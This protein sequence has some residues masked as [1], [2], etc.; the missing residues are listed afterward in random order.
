MSGAAWSGFLCS[1]FV[2]NIVT[3]ELPLLL[4]STAKLGASMPAPK[5]AH[6]GPAMPSRSFAHLDAAVSTFGLSRPGPAM[7][8]PAG[9]TLES[10]TFLRSHSRMDAALPALGLSKPDSSISPRSLA[11]PGLPALALRPADLGLL[12]SLQ[13]SSRAEF[14]VLLVGLARLGPCLS[15]LDRVTVESLPFTRSF[16]RVELALLTL[17]ASQP[18]SS[19]SL[20]SSS[21]SGA[22]A[23]PWGTARTGSCLLA[24]D[25]GSTASIPSTRSLA[26]VDLAVF[27]LNRAHYEPLLPSQR[28][29][30]PRLT[31]LQQQGQSTKKC[32]SPSQS[33]QTEG[34]LVVRNLN[35]WR[36][37]H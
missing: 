14:L 16:A 27:A 2:V 31:K 37:Q 3:L 33:P 36:F 5:F 30:R 11:H 25:S 23:L 26:R 21:H 13:S 12:A 9:A 10:P 28:E 24:S 17:C 32:Q 15:A 35:A 34:S 4:R 20:R 8:V 7:L 1:L 6:A 22:A 18:G 29:P 19:P